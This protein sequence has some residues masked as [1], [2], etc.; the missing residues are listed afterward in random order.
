MMHLHTTLMC[1]GLALDGLHGHIKCDKGRSVLIA[2]A[3]ASHRL[4]AVVLLSRV[5]VLA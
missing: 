2:H 3:D 4:Q 5:H 1:T